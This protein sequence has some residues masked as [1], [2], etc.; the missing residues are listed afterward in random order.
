MTAPKI[1]K[2]NNISTL[3][4]NYI[5]LKDDL[6]MLNILNKINSISVICKMKKIVVLN[7]EMSGVKK[8]SSFKKMTS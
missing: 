6:S 3:L 1:P 4:K 5:L 7:F 8:M 2:I